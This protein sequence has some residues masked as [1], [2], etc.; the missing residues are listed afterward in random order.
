MI[1]KDK[2]WAIIDKELF[3]KIFN[4]SESNER[5]LYHFLVIVYK[6]KNNTK[7]IK[8][9]NINDLNNIK[10]YDI[11]Y[12]YYVEKCHFYNKFNNVLYAEG[13]PYYIHNIG[14]FLIGGDIPT[15]KAD[16]EMIE[17]MF[18]EYNKS[19]INSNSIDDD[20]EFLSLN[21]SVINF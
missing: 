3:D 6:N 2:N 13:E 10:E 19:Y 8:I 1:F 15:T 4:D 17:K 11:I 9:D 20:V 12:K 5:Y 18:E 21:K 16:K 7:T 14:Y